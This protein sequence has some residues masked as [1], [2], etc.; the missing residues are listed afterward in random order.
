MRSPGSTSSYAEDSQ[1]TLDFL[2]L[3]GDSGG[4]GL[5]LSPG[6]GV[7]SQT[8]GGRAGAPHMQRLGSAGHLTAPHN[9]SHPPQK[10]DA[11]SN[12]QQTRL[13]SN[14][15]AAFTR[16]PSGNQYNGGAL[17]ASS[18]SFLANPIS[19]TVSS[20]SHAPAPTAQ[21]I[22]DD[23]DDR[24]SSLHRSNDS[25]DSTRLLY[26]TTAQDEPAPS[27]TLDPREASAGLSSSRTRA[28]TIGI[29]D[30][31]KEVF[32]RRRAGTATGM[33]PHALQMAAFSDSASGA[34]GEF[35]NGTSGL[36]RS[37]RG[38]SLSQDDV[39]ERIMRQKLRFALILTARRL[40]LGLI[41][42]DRSPLMAL[43]HYLQSTSNRL[44]VCGLVTWIQRR[45]PPSYKAFLRHMEPSKV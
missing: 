42:P 15:V 4:D 5:A 31:S 3:D 45:H 17:P 34:P 16:T 41:L 39:S 18:S 35:M 21:V 33:T 43:Q 7:D 20:S 29:L 6:P 38:L 30:D 1:R 27:M 14:T 23:Y 28:A 44:E 22:I 13:R 9:Q 36:A 32:M 40:P 11:F 24:N 26:A 37:M 25:T 12:Q 8:N 2:G 19:S 10:L